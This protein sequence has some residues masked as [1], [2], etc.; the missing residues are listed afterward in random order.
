MGEGATVCQPLGWSGAI[1][2]MPNHGLSVDALRPAW[3]SWIA[4]G[5]SDHR[6]TLVSTWRIA[7][8][9]ASDH[10]PVSP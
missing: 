4:I 8:S 10:S 6:L 3:P 1:C 5:M 7:S 2:S 9:L